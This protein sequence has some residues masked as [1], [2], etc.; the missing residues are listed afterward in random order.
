MILCLQH[1]GSGTGKHNK[2]L[3]EGGEEKSSKPELNDSEV[4]C[5]SF[6]SFLDSSTVSR[7]SLNLT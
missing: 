1:F 2:A 6:L 4:D 3:C 5:D 7:L